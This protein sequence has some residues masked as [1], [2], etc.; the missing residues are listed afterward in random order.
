MWKGNLKIHLFETD[1]LLKL[2]IIWKIFDKCQTS[3][4]GAGLV[5]FKIHKSHL[6]SALSF[7]SDNLLTM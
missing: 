4:I 1:S 3:K 6:T 7:L 2:Y 5:N